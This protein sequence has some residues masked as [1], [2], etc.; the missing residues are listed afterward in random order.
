LT[1]GQEVADTLLECGMQ[2]IGGIA[3][4]VKGI[5][6]ISMM[7]ETGIYDNI[8]IVDQVANRCEA[9]DIYP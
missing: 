8:Q 7:L 5:M 9:S 2:D 3:V 1:V 6:G 4:D